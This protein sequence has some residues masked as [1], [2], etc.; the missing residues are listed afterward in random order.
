MFTCT[1]IYRDVPFAHRQHRHSGNCSFI[2]GHNWG[3]GLEFGCKQ[4]DERGFVIAEP[5]SKL[6]RGGVRLFNALANPGN[7]KEISE[8]SMDG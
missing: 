4:L 8:A 2:H 7:E 5:R 3:I 1:K 6:S